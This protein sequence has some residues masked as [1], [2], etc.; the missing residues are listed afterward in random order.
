M[1]APVHSP[2]DSVTNVIA[3]FKWIGSGEAGDIGDFEKDF[4]FTPD[5]FSY[6]EWG[7]RVIN[8]RFTELTDTLKAL[9]PANI[10]S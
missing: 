7:N 6:D 9:L 2:G 4:E 8:F 3:K 1:P 5:Q 10:D